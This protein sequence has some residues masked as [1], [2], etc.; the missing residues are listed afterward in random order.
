MDILHYIYN[1]LANGYFYVVLILLVSYLIL[2]KQHHLLKEIIIS[3]NVLSL[4]TYLLFVIDGIYTL[5]PLIRQFNDERDIFFSYRISG[6][7]GIYNWVA[8]INA[9]FIFVLLLIKK[10]RNSIW[11]TAW[12]LLCSAPF[13]YERLIIWITSL[14]RDYIPST[15]SAY[16][17]GF[18]DNSPWLDYLSFLVITYFIRKHFIKKEQSGIG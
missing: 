5:Y 12:I 16:S 10:I 1:I 6:P 4:I 17:K 11:I 8:F 13:N 2:E 15:W 18:F 9:L 14:Y 7:Y 3:S